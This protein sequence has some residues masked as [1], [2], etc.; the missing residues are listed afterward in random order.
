M[1][2]TLLLLLV[3]FFSLES[4]YA[5]KVSFGIAGG[6]N[7]TKVEFDDNNEVD[8]E[9]QLKT[10]FNGGIYTQISLLKDKLFLQPQLMYSAEGFV[11]KVQNTDNGNP[12]SEE[13]ELETNLNFLNIPITLIF[14]PTKFLNF[15]FGPEFGHMLK[16]V[17]KGDFKE[18][19]VTDIYNQNELGLNLGIGTTIAQVVDINVRYNHGLTDLFDGSSSQLDGSEGSGGSGNQVP[20]GEWKL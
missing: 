11:S 3:S 16:A 12:D 14:K 18:T 19:T 1:K 13:K 15:Q 10:S 4:S 8:F 7:M 17:A 2:K 5:Q 6:L 20:R 9:K